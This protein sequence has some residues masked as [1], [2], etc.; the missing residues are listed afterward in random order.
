MPEG[1]N[2]NHDRA[3][4][5]SVADDH[6]QVLDVLEQALDVDD[7]EPTNYHIREALQILHLENRKEIAQLLNK[8]LD[9]DDPDSVAFFIREAIELLEI[10]TQVPSTDQ[11]NQEESVK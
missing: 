3:D 2:G 6:A 11:V 9:T 10:E 5:P 1:N 4:S 7:T 8:A